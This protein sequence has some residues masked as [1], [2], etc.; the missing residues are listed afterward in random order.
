MGIF[1]NCILASDI[2]NTLVA[3]GYI[4]PRNVEK[5]DYF[6]KE[7]GIFSLATGRGAGA[8][9]IVLDT[10]KDVTISIV[11]NGCLIYDY[12]NKKP[13]YE[14]C[15]SKEDYKVADFVCNCGLNVGCEIHCGA[16]AYT[17]KRTSEVDDHQRYEDFTA[18][19]KTYAE[20]SAFNWNKVIFMFDSFEDRTKLEKM[21]ENES[22]SC[23]FIETTVEL[24]GRARP[25]FEVVPKGISKATAIIKLAEILNAP[26][27]NIFAIGDYY[28]DLEMLKAADISAVTADSPEDIKEI[29]DYIT[30]SCK[31]GAVAD[32]I[33]YLTNKFMR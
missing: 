32:F 19:D 18:E 15:I 31:D 25:Y 29:A 7:G 14:A 23:D 1:E 2:D 11:A 8:I 28:N 9:S 16:D 6:I 24:D 17:L 27:G 30:V 21:L 13:L 3:D 4:N 33:D 12:K 26:K 22:F 20:L 10:L 5:I